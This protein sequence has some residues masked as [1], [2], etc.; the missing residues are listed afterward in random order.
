MTVRDSYRYSHTLG[1]CTIDGQGFF[2]PVDVGMGRDRVLYVLNRGTMEMGDVMF[3]KR[4]TVCTT[5]DEYL[6]QF[7]GG[8]TGDGQIMWPSSIAVDENEN[9]FIADEALHRITILDK[10]G[11][12]LD[13]WGK[14]GRGEGEFDRPA[15]I[16]FEKD[17]NLLVVDGLNNRVQRYTKEG[18]FLGQWG[19]RGTGDGEFNMPWGIA[20]D[21]ADNVYVADWRNDRIQK[22][23]ADGKHLA[24]WGSSG[25]GEGQFNRPSGLAVDQEGNIYVADWGNER[26]QVLD[27]EGAFVA[28]FRGESGLSKWAEDW[29]AS[30]HMD[31]LEV[32][33]KSDMDPPLD[34]PVGEFFRNEPAG[35]EKLFWAPT[36]VKVDAEGKVYVIDT[37]RHRIQVYEKA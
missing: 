14:N 10:K 7:S 5:D 25:E 33:Q 26:V 2:H 22:F 17:G 3:Y 19:S 11:R 27:P 23:E 16:V 1:F 34:P 8:G 6:G 32:R 21:H 18:T 29:F 28:Q 13:K 31:L 37:C 9:L 36:T 15:N 30:D 20:V 4:I 24:S 35:I 12:F